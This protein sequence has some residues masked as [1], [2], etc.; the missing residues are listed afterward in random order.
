[1]AKLTVS[2]LN[3]DVKCFCRVDA[4]NDSG[5]TEGKVSAGAR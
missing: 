4:Y 3:Q 2:C 5:V 1:M